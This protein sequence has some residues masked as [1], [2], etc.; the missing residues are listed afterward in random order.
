MKE[1]QGIKLEE[2]VRQASEEVIND[3]KKNTVGIIKGLI[4]KAEQL[5]GDLNKLESE[6]GKK[7]KSL[8]DT[9]ECLKKAGNGD[10]SVLQELNKDN[11]PTGFANI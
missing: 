6:T 2:L 8:D 11:N 10:W 1:I 4:L 5:K 9:L 3:K 7:R